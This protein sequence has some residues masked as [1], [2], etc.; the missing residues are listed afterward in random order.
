MAPG[1]CLFEKTDSVAC[2]LI[3]RPSPAPVRAHPQH[4]VEIGKPGG[5]LDARTISRPGPVALIVD[6]A[7]S[8][9]NPNNPTTRPGATFMGQFMDHDMTF[10]LG[11]SA[12]RAD[13]AGGLAQLPHAGA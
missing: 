13:G 8:E 9:N 11:S 6:P 10:D 7:L 12:R 5:I 4:S 1:A 3:F 2:F